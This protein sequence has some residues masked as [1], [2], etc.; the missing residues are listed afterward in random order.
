VDGLELRWLG[1][2]GGI[3]GELEQREVWSCG[4]LSLALVICGCLER[5]FAKFV[6]FL[7]E[8]DK[9]VTSHWLVDSISFFGRAFHLVFL[10]ASPEALIFG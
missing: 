3:Y 8:M 5:L 9:I 6:D 1:A 10:Q 4:K 7:L 2:I